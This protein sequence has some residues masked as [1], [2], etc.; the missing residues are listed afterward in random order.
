MTNFAQDARHV[1]KIVRVNMVEE[2][3]KVMSG[4]E[5]VMLLAPW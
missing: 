4:L 1:S 5:L 3:T 2:K